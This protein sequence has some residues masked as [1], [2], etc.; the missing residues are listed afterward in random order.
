MKRKH[1]HMNLNVLNKCEQ[2]LLQA[3]SKH[4]INHNKDNESN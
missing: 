4:I 1:T 2:L 3:N